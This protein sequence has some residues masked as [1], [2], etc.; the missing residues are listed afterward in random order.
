MWT[1]T[2]NFIFHWF[3]N[4]ESK[5]EEKSKTKRHRAKSKGLM[6]ETDELLYNRLYGRLCTVNQQFMVLKCVKYTCK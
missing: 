4:R 2:Q 1:R 6:K 3:K 5:T